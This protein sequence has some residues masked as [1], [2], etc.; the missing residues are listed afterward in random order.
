MISN[1]KSSVKLDDLGGKPTISWQFFS[2][3]KTSQGIIVETFHLQFIKAPEGCSEFRL[4]LGGVFH[5]WPGEGSGI[6]N[7]GNGISF[8]KERFQ[9]LR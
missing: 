5:R 6:S 1:G 8:K 2:Q 7:M 3:N 4:V 9:I